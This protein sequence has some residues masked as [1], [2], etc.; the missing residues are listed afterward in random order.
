M[1]DN[2]A[3]T[4]GA[5]TTIRTDDVGG[6]QYQVVKLD[7]GADGASA[8]LSNSNPIPVSDAGGSLTV[9]VGSVAAGDNNI[10]NVDVA[11]VPA[12]PF[13]V[14]ADAAVAAG[15]AGSIQAKLRLMTSQLDAIKTAVETLDNTVAGSELQ[16]DI[17][18]GGLTPSK[19]GTATITT[20]ADSASSATLK[21]ANASRLGIVIA[22]DSTVILYV[23]YGTT[24]SSTD[25]TYKLEAGE[26]L[27]DEL[28]TGRIDGIWASDASGSARITE[29]TA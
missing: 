9:D 3:I 20:V 27:R 10:G 26:T 5:G 4:A 1:A 16:V 21:A 23:K 13:G 12:D 29:L 8:A 25:W 15:A 24:A 19:A 22:N 14:N 11:T 18:S 6:V 28:Y 7:V 17:V 2:V